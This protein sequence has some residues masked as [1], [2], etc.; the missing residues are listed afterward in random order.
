[1]F[2]EDIE[3]EVYVIEEVFFEDD[4]VFFNRELVVGRIEF[5]LVLVEVYNW[6]YN[7]REVEFGMLILDVE[8]F[9]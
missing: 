3:Y 9:E 7:E 2:R 4:F 1:M 6:E 8:I 5:D